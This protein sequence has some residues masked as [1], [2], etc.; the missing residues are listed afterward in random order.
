MIHKHKKK[1]GWETLTDAYKTT[2]C[3]L[4]LFFVK[5]NRYLVPAVSKPNVAVVAHRILVFPMKC[6]TTPPKI[7][8]R[9]ASFHTHRSTIL[10]GMR[11]TRKRRNMEKEETCSIATRSSNVWR[12]ASSCCMWPCCHLGERLT[13][14]DGE[15]ML[16]DLTTLIVKTLA[17]RRLRLSLM[18]GREEGLRRRLGTMAKKGVCSPARGSY[19]T[20]VLY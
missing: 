2:F 5:S 1:N 20:R 11:G 13:I 14:S 10:G 8:N 17:T 15:L 9:N 3:S 19:N 6:L 12:L 7:F 16:A 18:L 4:A